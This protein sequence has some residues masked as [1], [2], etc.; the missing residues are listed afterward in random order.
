MDGGRLN[1]RLL[2][3]AAFLVAFAMGCL[4]LVLWFNDPT[5]GGGF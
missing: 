4:W 5:S 3:L 1:A 2:L